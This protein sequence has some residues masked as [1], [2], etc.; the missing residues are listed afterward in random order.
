[1]TLVL[2]AALG[3]CDGA[4]PAEP[5]S[6]PCDS[7]A[8]IEDAAR[9]EVRATGKVVVAL[10][11]APG[12]EHPALEPVKA[13]LTRYLGSLWGAEVV[14]TDDASAEGDAA[15]IRL[16]TSEARQTQAKLTVDD[17]YALVRTGAALEVLAD[18]DV[19]LAFGAYALL[20]AL[21]ARFLHPMQ[22]YVP[23]LGR[24]ALPRELSVVRKPAFAQRGVQLHTLHPIEYLEP[25]NFPGERN[26]AEARVLIDWLVKTGQNHLQWVLLETAPLGAHTQDILDYAHGRGLKVGVAVQ[27]W[28]GAALQNN[29][30]L[31]KDEANWQAQMDASLEKLLAYDWDVVELALGEFLSAEPQAVIEWLDHATEKLATLAPEV[32]V[33]VQNHVG[34]YEQLYVTYQGKEEY[35]YHLPKHCDSRLGQSVHTLSLFDLYRDWA[36]YAHPNFHLQREYLLEVLQT[37]RTLYFP[38]SAYWITADVD[39]P[40]FLPEYVHARWLD[41]QRLVADTAKLGLPPLHG[42]LLFSSGHEW[43]Y[44][45][46]DYLTAKMLWEPTRPLADFFEHAAAS[47]GSC[48]A[49]VGASLTEFTA[50]QTEGLF[51]RRLLPYVQGEDIVVDLGYLAGLET[52]PKRIPFEDVFAMSPEE[53]ASFEKDVVAGLDG[54]ATAIAPLEADLAARCRGADEAV[55][56]WCEELRDGYSIVRLRLAHSSAL[57]RAVLDRANGG[58]GLALLDEASRLSAAARAVVAG[59]EPHY[60][61]ELSRLVDAYPNATFYPYGYLRQAHTLCLWTRQELQASAVVVD[62]VTAGIASLPRCQQ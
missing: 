39:V 24:V 41:I 56:P 28:G 22:E 35:Y 5:P 40:L 4:S 53:R 8:F 16:S 61:F 29:Y 48:R 15:T 46:T 51:E 17:G 14:I 9:W 18:D 58:D 2:L 49:E 32:Q 19:N 60:R 3:A 54:M 13:D 33:N 47:L 37:R 12:S 38:E 30:V 57:Y 23:S 62:G 55:S 52:H 43:G 44:W 20:E 11:L 21:G 31:V 25:F 1:M 59:R 6:I 36:T 27:V 26:F 45:M 7:S 34:N 42:H 50:L 10:E